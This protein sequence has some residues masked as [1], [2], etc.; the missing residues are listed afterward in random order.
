[1]KNAADIQKIS[2]SIGANVASDIAI[3]GT[4]P[5]FSRQLNADISAAIKDGHMTIG[6]W[7]GAFYFW[8][9]PY[10]DPQTNVTTTVGAAILAS[11]SEKAKFVSGTLAAMSTTIDQFGVDLLTS[12]PFWTAVGKGLKT[13]TSSGDGLS[14]GVAIFVGIL[15]KV[16]EQTP[17]SRP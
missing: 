6:G 2:N 8:N 1:M 10:T 17:C 12:G 14:M 9:A 16:E 7:G 4:L 3:S 11:E 5:P 13:V 15:D